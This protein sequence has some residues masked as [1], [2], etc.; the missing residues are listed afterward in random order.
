ML[1]NA[2]RTVY[3]IEKI[4]SEI[5]ALK[6][7]RIEKESVE[8]Q[9]ATKKAEE[10]LLQTKTGIAEVQLQV[11]KAEITQYEESIKKISDEYVKEVKKR[12]GS[13]ETTLNNAYAANWNTIRESATSVRTTIEAMNSTLEKSVPKIQEF[14]NVLIKADELAA[15]IASNGEMFHLYELTHRGRGGEV[16]VLIIVSKVLHGFVI[17]ATQNPGIVPAELVQCV[18][19]VVGQVETQLQ[20]ATP[21]PRA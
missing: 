14:S 1:S 6:D 16:V 2:E 13:L 11:L 3:D 15:Q 12:L 17:W 4:M 7:L 19:I 8:G 5:S 10:Q 18:Q 20:K 9:I 21:N